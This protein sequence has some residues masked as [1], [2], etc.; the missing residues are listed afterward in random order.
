M[1][2]H[3]VIWFYGADA[4]GKSAVGW[5]AY[6]QLVTRGLPTAYVDTDYLGFCDPRPD[7]P[8]A[9]VAA[10]LSAVWA[11]FPKQDVR[12]LV[13]SG[14]LVTGEHRRIFAAALAGC[15][16]TTVLLRAQPS[17]IRARIRRR[18]EV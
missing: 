18:R 16:L 14:I 6:R 7:D 11:N 3:S 8:A 4:V 17:T 9:L 15:S 2:T 12:Y 10:N 5:E 13:V 1:T